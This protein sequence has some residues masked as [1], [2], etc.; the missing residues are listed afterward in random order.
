MAI[1]L[2]VCE[3]CNQA[4]MRRFRHPLKE[5]SL[6]PNSFWKFW[7]FVKM[8]SNSNTSGNVRNYCEQ[9]EWL[10]VLLAMFLFSFG[11]LISGCISIKCSWYWMCLGG[12]KI[13]EKN[14]IKNESSEY[15]HI[16]LALFNSFSIFGHM[17][18]LR[19]CPKQE[20]V[21][22]RQWNS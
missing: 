6:P 2:P 7:K 4:I 22:V 18:F 9:F 3:F 15:F 1:Y 19:L 12:S 21:G 5:D 11:L 8:R 14:G 20:M 16:P 10:L 17:H 13:D